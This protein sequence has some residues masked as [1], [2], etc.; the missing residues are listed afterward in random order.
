MWPNGSKFLGRIFLD[1]LTGELPCVLVEVLRVVKSGSIIL[2][3]A[4]N[5]NFIQE[6]I[7]LQLVDL[8]KISSLGN[9]SRLNKYQNN[10]ISRNVN[11][12]YDH[13]LYVSKTPSSG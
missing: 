2:F 1:N 7:A 9:D 11:K 12:Y 10:A 6:H 8:P 5:M 3:D 4:M 13:T